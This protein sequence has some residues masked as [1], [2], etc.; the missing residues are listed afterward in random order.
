MKQLSLFL[1]L[2]LLVFSCNSEKK[3]YDEV[4]ALHDEVMPLMDNIMNLKQELKEKAKSLEKDTI[5]D[6][7]EEIMQIQAL[8]MKL[9]SA[10]KSMMVWMREF[11]HDY[12]TVAKAEL[13]EYLEKQK[14]RITAVGLFMREAIKDAENY[15]SE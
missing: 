6:N 11:H 4:M 7:S 14:Q 8:I 2:A 1:L 12:E 3:T 13:T 15:F 10:D 9:D 5:S